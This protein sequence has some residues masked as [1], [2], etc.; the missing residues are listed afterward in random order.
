MALTGHW[1]KT[2]KH[3][4]SCC[5]TPQSPMTD[6]RSNSPR[7]VPPELDDYAALPQDDASSWIP[8]QTDSF[9]SDSSTLV[10]P[11]DPRSLD[12]LASLVPT[13]QPLVIGI[14]GPSGGGKTSLARWLV[15]QHPL[16]V[17]IAMDDFCY[18]DRQ[19]VVDAGGDAQHPH[20]FEAPIGYDKERFMS[21]V[22]EVM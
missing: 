9:T 10:N 2:T 15:S 5:K 17:H 19:A 11:V 7:P 3:P 20:P 16:S 22:A 13:G 18:A 6:S 12:A 4:Q 14:W 8:G 1:L 21:R